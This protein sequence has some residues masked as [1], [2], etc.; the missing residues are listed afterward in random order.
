MCRKYLQIYILF[1]SYVM[2]ILYWSMSLTTLYISRALIVNTLAYMYTYMYIL[3]KMIT[4]YSELTVRG[5]KHLL[6]IRKMD[7]LSVVHL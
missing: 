1:V 5:D 2:K 3:L 7:F 6:L 4:G